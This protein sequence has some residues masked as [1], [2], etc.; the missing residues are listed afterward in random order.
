MG[1]CNSGGNWSDKLDKLLG[2]TNGVKNVLVIK[3]LAGIVFLN[4]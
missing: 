2:D 1:M 4:I 3:Y